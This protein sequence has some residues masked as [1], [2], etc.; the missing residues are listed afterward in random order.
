VY[1]VPVNEFLNI[2][3]TPALLDRQLEIK[4]VFGQVV[5]VATIDANLVQ[6]KTESF[7]SGMYFITIE[8]LPGSHRFIKE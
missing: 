2:K 7:A 6:L 3:V 5:A 1:P 8:G 4:N